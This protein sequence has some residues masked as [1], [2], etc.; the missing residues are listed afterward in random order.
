MPSTNT[1]SPVRSFA[2]S[3]PVLDRCARAAAKA[4][5][6]E[7]TGNSIIASANANPRAAQFVAIAKA[8]IAECRSE[9][10]T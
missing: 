2:R 3:S 4:S 7:F 5:G 10:G 8:V 9:R 1:S 6:Y